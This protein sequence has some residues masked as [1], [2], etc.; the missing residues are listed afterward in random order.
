MTDIQMNGT[1]LR[2]DPLADE[3]LQIVNGATKYKIMVQCVESGFFDAIESVGEPASLELLSKKF[4]Y[5]LEIL[6][7][8]MNTLVS[9]RLIIVEQNK[10]G[11]NTYKNSPSTS[12]YLTRSKK[13]TMIGLIMMS[14]K[15][16]LPLTE[17]LPELLKNGLPKFDINR[18]IAAMKN[19][20]NK[21]GVNLTDIKN[22]KNITEM[23]MKTIKIEDKISPTCSPTKTNVSKSNKMPPMPNGMNMNKMPPMPNGMMAMKMSMMST[24]MMSSMMPKPNNMDNPPCD[25]LSKFIM[26][27]DAFSCS[28]ASA[29]VRAFDLSPHREA[30]DL[31][32]GSGRISIELSNTYTNMKVTMFDLPPVVQLAQKMFPNNSDGTLQYKAGD[33]FEDDIPSGDLYILG[34]VLHAWDELRVDQLLNKVF[35]KL[36]PG[37]SLLV[38][39]KVLSDDKSSPEICATNDLILALMS[40]GKERNASE[41]QK[42]FAKHGFTNVQFRYIDGYNYCDAIL[43]KK[44]F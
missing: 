17:N 41:Y 33:F 44:P 16:C 43:V 18:N 31:G 21:N 42:L 38:L 39:E 28:C 20:M 10:K 27:T 15:M 19:G 14:D 1:E 5:D 37:G 25:M 26:S 3:I 29:V 13:P 40:K 36:P 35:A 8:L 9:Y 7:R 6:E 30:V 2:S 22:E 12:K 11:S 23:K 34:H 32:G 24:S 4:G